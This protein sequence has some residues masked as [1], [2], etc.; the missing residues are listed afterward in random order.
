MAQRALEALFVPPREFQPRS[1]LAPDPLRERLAAIVEASAL[2]LLDPRRIQAM[3][4]D[5]GVVKLCRTHHM[6]LLVTSLVLSALERQTDTSGRWLDA[7]QV[8]K[9]LG[10][11]HAGKTSFR[12][13]TRQSAPVLQQMLD[14]QM[15]KLSDET[16]N[17]ELR[18]RLAA[19]TNV[20]IPDGCAFKL[21]SVL[22]GYSPGT[23]NP[24]ELK[25]H[26]VYCVKTGMASVKETAGRV[27]D[28][29]GFA[30]TRWEKGALYIWDLGYNDN[31][32]FID[33]VKAEAIPLQRLKSS[34]NPV[35][36]AWYDEHGRHSI[37]D[38]DGQ[39]MRLNDATQSVV[40]AT[41]PLDLDVELR[42][43]KGRTEVVRVVCIPYG[44]E[45]GQELE[46]D[47]YYLTA[48][49]R[50]VFTVFDV[51]EIYRLRWEVELF[52]RNWHGALRM[53]DVHRLSHPVSVHVHV[54]CSLVAATLARDIHAGLERISLEHAAADGFAHVT[55]ESQRATPGASPP[56]RP[57]SF[58]RQRRGGHD[59][60]A[61]HR[62]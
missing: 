5:L 6:G 37:V 18:G 48:L 25:L 50:E 34:A 39:P 28:N 19:F 27:H 11:P 51:A 54:L 56:G 55:S 2:S 9:D 7:Q 30:P 22:S 33:A 38:A 21:A 29:E 61:D 23:G 41:G 46:Q 12:N 44:K 1:E 24:A 42:D 17:V 3:A 14:R 20:L 60:D 59:L 36:L 43:A 62:A 31:E 4:E 57:C 32:R 53:D 49:P 8:Y 26:A 58:E 40:P 47:R 16:D 52:F 35:A 10:G 15:K 13:R 45:I